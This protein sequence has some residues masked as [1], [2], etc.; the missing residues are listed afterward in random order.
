MLLRTIF[1]ILS[2]CSVFTLWAIAV[3]ADDA[4]QG[5]LGTGYMSAED[6]SAD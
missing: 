3:S 5:K 6:R 1:A 2:V 4:K